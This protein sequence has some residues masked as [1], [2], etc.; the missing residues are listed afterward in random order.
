MQNFCQDFENVKAFFGK[1]RAILIRNQLNP[2][3]VIP[4]AVQGMPFSNSQEIVACVSF[5]VNSHFLKIPVG[6]DFPPKMA[7]LTL[8]MVRG[9]VVDFSLTF[10]SRCSSALIKARCHNASHK[11]LAF[12]EIK[13]HKK[14][15]K[16]LANTLSDAL[17]HLEFFF[18]SQSPSYSLKVLKKENGSFPDSHSLS[19]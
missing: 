7:F 13:I 14:K 8:T 12:F 15:P 2:A 6:H 9:H 11:S 5:S 16:I 10:F 19:F 4:F 1:F 18:D 17:R 3:L